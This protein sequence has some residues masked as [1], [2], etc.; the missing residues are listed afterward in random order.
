MADISKIKLPDNNTYN[1][2]DAGAARSSHT[3]GANTITSG[4]LN[5]HPENSPVLIPFIHNDIAFLTKRGGSATISYDDVTQSIDLES[6]FNGKPDYTCNINPTGITTIVI[7]LTLHKTFTWTNT[8]YCDFG[9]AGWRAKNVKLEVKNTNYTSDVWTQKYVNT[10][11]GGG[12]FAP[13]FDHIPVGAQNAGGGFNKIR[14]T[15]STFAT[16]T[17]FRISQIG[18]YNYGSSGVA[19]TYL[20]KGGGG[21]YG[22]ITPINN[23]AI[24]LGSSSNYWKNLY[25]TN[26]NGV[27][28]GSSPKFTDTNTYDRNRYNQAIKAWGTKIIAGNII[29]AASDGL[30]HHLKQGTAFDIRYPLLYLAG[31]TN[32]SAT[33]T[34]TYDCIP[35]T[36]TTTQSITLTAYK[37]VYI[38]GTLSGSTF[39]P[40]S[41]TPLTQTMTNNDGYYYM[42][43][44]IAY[45][46]TGV[47]LIDDH[48]IFVY[49]GN[50]AYD[51]ANVSTGVEANVESGSTTETAYGVAF[52]PNPNN[53]GEF[54]SVRKSNDAHLN[55]K[56]GTAGGEGKMELVLGNAT[57]KS[58]AGN[59]SGILSLYSE[60]TAAHEIKGAATSSVVNH[61]LPAKSGTIYNSGNLGIYREDID[62]ST[63][64]FGGSGPYYSSTKD[65]SSKFSKIYAA[66]LY[67]YSGIGNVAIDVCI[68]DPNSYDDIYDKIWFMVYSASSYTPTGHVNVQ[69]FGELK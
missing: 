66:N 38:K 21:M 19:E 59:K 6:C 15:F 36:I 63:L 55:I 67:N 48:R 60:G 9:F 34:N 53:S 46:T 13:T 1:I 52:V 23:S 41:T 61:T 40:V 14:F 47:Y 20:W 28:V 10:N 26:I 27:A 16:S 12:N 65:Y 32:A 54:N 7:E 33:T 43:L 62:L 51:V 44:G 25:V 42:L 68:G 58:A 37:P 69:F 8:V 35:F 4:Y 22:D 57:A 17:I 24:S 2:K 56:A 29:V 45:S 5:T 18:I 31:D 39:T 3:Q 11:L 49:K 64:T 30:Y 50:V